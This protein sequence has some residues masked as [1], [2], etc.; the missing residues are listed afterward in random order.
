MVR[1]ASPQCGECEA[2]ARCGETDD[3]ARDDISKCCAARAFFNQTDGLERERAE[4]RVGT[5]S[6]GADHGSGGGV[7]S[8]VEA[9]PGDH[10]ENET[11]A[12]VDDERAPWE[13]AVGTVLNQA[14]DEVARRSADGGS[15]EECEPRQIAHRCGIPTTVRRAMAMPA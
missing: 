10:A 15:N 1:P 12:D 6:A 2:C 5:H 7:K 3:E 9:E 4:C 13:R 8:V 11:A 14:I